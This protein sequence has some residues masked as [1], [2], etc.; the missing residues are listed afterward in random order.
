MHNLFWYLLR[1]QREG[2][3]LP[4][5]GDRLHEVHHRCL[6][7]SSKSLKLQKFSQSVGEFLQGHLLVDHQVG[8][9]LQLGDL[10]R[11]KLW[12][13]NKW[14][15]KQLSQWLA[16]DHPSRVEH[17]QGHPLEVL[18]RDHR[19]AVLQSHLSKSCQSRHHKY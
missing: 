17:L 6:L 8:V 12:S 9:L 3:R 15:L 16:V 5:V 2:Q 19:L 14:L 7:Q 18:Q 10:L 11:L 1:Y 4:Q 13:N